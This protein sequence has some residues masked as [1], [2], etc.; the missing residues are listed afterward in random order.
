M[1]VAGRRQRVG[2]RPQVSA[3]NPQQQLDQ[4]PAD[5]A[6]RLELAE[7]V[8]GLPEVSEEPSRISVPGAR[9]LVLS[10]AA[11]KAHPQRS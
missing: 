4:Q 11:A 2:P 7:R 1:S 8:F 10:D 5:P 3:G 9:A 6:L